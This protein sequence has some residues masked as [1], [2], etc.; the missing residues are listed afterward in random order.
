MGRTPRAQKLPMK[1]VRTARCIFVL[2]CYKKKILKAS[3]KREES[4]EGRK[5]RF[6]GRLYSRVEAE[7]CG[8]RE[9]NAQTWK[10][11]SH[12]LAIQQRGACKGKGCPR[13]H[14]GPWEAWSPSCEPHLAAQLGLAEHRIQGACELGKATSLSSLAPALTVVPPTAKARPGPGG[15]NRSRKPFEC[16]APSPWGHSPCRRWV[17]IN[18]RIGELT[19][20]SKPDLFFREACVDMTHLLCD[21][22]C[23]T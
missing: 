10:C 1:E 6:S 23:F 13:H 15:L 12:P 20:H 22:L 18:P 4:F 11:V 2:R 19:Y 7:P 3:K 16:P 14:R 8:A 9:R 5:A 21:S 17:L